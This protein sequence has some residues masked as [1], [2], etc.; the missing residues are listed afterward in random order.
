MLRPL[1]TN[2]TMSFKSRCLFGTLSLCLMA[3]AGIQPR[4][5]TVERG[6]TVT[7][8]AKAY[9]IPATDIELAN[10]TLLSDGLQPGE[11]LYIPF[12]SSPDW[13]K[14]FYDEPSREAAPEIQ[15]AALKVPF[16]WPVRGPISSKFGKRYMQGRGKHFH[17]GLDIAAK[18]GTPVKAARSGHVVYA[19]NRIGGYGN[20]VI[21][22]H[23]D[24][25]S[26]V[27]AHL[28]KMNVKKGQYV[29]RGQQVGTVGRT[30][31]STGHHLH[32]EVR[33]ARRPVDP[34]PLL[35]RQYAS[36]Q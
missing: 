24:S 5:H 33:A 22:Q 26:T 35:Q 34:Y 21:V 3:C 15:I 12:E 8:L 20:M 14:E 16:V 29:A 18:K 30:G 32:F 28:T 13:D 9:A 36:K 1:I 10:R 2:Q 19:T 17:E 25:L 27:Y 23:Q 11:K 31:R 7:R 4:Y 6:E